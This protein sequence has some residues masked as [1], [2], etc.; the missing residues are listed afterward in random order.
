MRVLVISACSQDFCKTPAISR[1]ESDRSVNRFKVRTGS[2][3]DLFSRQRIDRIEC[4]DVNSEV[5]R[6]SAKRTDP[7]CDIQDSSANQLVRL[8]EK[9]ASV[10]F[11]RA[12]EQNDPIELESAFR[13]SGPITHAPDVRPFV[14]SGPD[15]SV[16][17][18]TTSSPRQSVSNQK[19]LRIPLL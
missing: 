19:T 5:V 9:I 6:L 4:S 2:F 18:P 7:A 13:L 16:K 3:P 15:V 17:A 14:S 8:E 11:E 12:T 1:Y 10:F